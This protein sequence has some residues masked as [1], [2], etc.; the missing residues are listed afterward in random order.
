MDK[1]RVSTGAPMPE[2]A[3][4][5]VVGPYSGKCHCGW[6]S[7]THEAIHD[8]GA[9]LADHVEAEHSDGRDDGPVA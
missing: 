2:P 5:V 8:A 9:A 1:A 6:E 4:C 3:D 7:P